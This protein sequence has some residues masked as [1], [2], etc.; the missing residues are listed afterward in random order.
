MLIL[1]VYHRGNEYLTVMMY[2]AVF[3]AGLIGERLPLM[4]ILI[5]IHLNVTKVPPKGL[6]RRP[7]SRIRNVGLAWKRL[8]LLQMWMLITLVKLG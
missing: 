3:V 5:K 2:T 7:K 6:P 8:K 4:I 1:L